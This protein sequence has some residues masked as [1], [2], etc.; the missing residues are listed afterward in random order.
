M[1][2]LQPHNRHEQ[3]SDPFRHYSRLKGPHE[4]IISTSLS[5]YYYYKNIYKSML[6][7]Q[8]NT[9][10]GDAKDV[11]IN[12]Y[13][14]ELNRRRRLSADCVVIIVAANLVCYRFG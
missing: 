14:S 12:V 9:L 8:K 11:I 10:L 5:E 1:W 2:T 13:P 7:Y 4:F 6:T 3:T